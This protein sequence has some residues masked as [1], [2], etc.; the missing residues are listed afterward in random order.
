[1]DGAEE[2]EA[3]S[4]R[5]RRFQVGI[6][7]ALAVVLAGVYLAPDPALLNARELMLLKAWLSL[8]ATMAFYL[9]FGAQIWSYWLW[10]AI[11]VFL[12]LASAAFAGGGV[13]LW[14]AACVEEKT[15]VGDHYESTFSYCLPRLGPSPEFE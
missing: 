2:K 14:H 5:N 15:T 10:K 3:S 7:I 8:S 4:D 1:M 6:G 11:F 12:V 9:V 13:G